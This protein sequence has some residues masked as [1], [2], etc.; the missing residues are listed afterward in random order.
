MSSSLSRA[1]P[2]PKNKNCPRQ[3]HFYSFP[4]GSRQILRICLKR[5]GGYITIPLTEIFRKE[6][7]VASRIPFCYETIWHFDSQIS[8]FDNSYLW[9]WLYSTPGAAVSG[10]QSIIFPPFCSIPLI[11]FHAPTQRAKTATDFRQKQSTTKKTSKFDYNL[12]FFVNWS[13]I[14]FL[15]EKRKS[16]HSYYDEIYKCGNKSF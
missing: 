5:G 14:V 15:N 6:Y 8:L 7:S 11:G 3:F 13:S 2:H 12:S 16:N 1:P 9:M 4:E 10:A